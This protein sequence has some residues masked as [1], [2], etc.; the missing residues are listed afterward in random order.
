MKLAPISFST[1]A[2][3]LLFLPSWLA[4]WAGQSAKNPFLLLLRLLLLVVRGGG[5]DGGDDDDE[6][7]EDCARVALFMARLA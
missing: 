2:P 3:W 4:G 5:D 6:V 1:F 7:E